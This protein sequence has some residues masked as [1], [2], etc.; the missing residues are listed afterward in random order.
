MRKQSITAC[1]C[2]SFSLA[3][4]GLDGYGAGEKADGR[5]LKSGCVPSLELPQ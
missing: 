4:V 2:Q 3:I 5:L 1:V